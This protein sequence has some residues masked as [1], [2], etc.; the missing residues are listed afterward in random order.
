LFLNA[1]DLLN[2]PIWLPALGSGKGT[3]MPVIRGRTILFGIE[4]WQ[5]KTQ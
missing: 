4:V 2:Q 5:K 1:N 3:T